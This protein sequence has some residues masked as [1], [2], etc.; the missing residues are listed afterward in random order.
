[1]PVVVKR[2][3]STSQ[4]L[5]SSNDHC[6]SRRN[7][8]QCRLVPK[9]GQLMR[10]FLRGVRDA[11]HNLRGSPGFT[12]TVAKLGENVQ[13]DVCPRLDPA[14]RFCICDVAF[15]DTRWTRTDYCRFH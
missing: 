9:W 8:L 3:P 14:E 4:P 6:A 13:I 10:A 2:D 11:T 7:H 12:A 5:Q 15:F 1:M